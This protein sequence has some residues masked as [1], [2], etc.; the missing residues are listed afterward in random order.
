LPNLSGTAFLAAET[1]F[2]PSLP[3]VANYSH[4]CLL[5]IMSI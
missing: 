3:L 2:P 1:F 5:I 4:S